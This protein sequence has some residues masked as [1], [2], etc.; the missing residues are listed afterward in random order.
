MLEEN[1]SKFYVP[2]DYV[3]MDK[4]PETPLMKVD[5]M[6]LTAADPEKARAERK[7]KY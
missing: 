7:I 1:Y 6:K 5:F 2:H 4:L 3:F